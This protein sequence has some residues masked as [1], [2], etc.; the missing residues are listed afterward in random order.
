GVPVAQALLQG[1]QGRRLH[2]H[3]D[4]VGVQPADQGRPLHV[5]VEDHAD[6]PLPVR[7][8]LVP[9]GAV[10][11][12]VHL[13]VLQKGPLPAPLLEPPPRD[14]PAAQTGSP[15]PS[16]PP[17]RG[18]RVAPDPATRSGKPLVLS[19]PSITD[20]FPEPLGPDTMIRGPGF[21][22]SNIEHRTLNIERPTADSP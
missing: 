3:R 17:P 2:E 13:G 22:T 15:P 6:A 10:V 20:D 18:G 11:V 16:L 9:Q 19:S 1:R 7:V 12:P 21:I 8:D 14:G 4:G 5:D